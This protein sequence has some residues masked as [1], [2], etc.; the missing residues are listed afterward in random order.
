MH[1]GRNDRLPRFP[2]LLFDDDGWLSPCDSEDDVQLAVEPDFLYDIEAA[3]D[4]RG[5]P[6]VLTVRDDERVVPHVTG[7]PE[8]GE[9]IRR[10]RG[11]FRAWTNAPAPDLR[12][13]VE[14]WLPGVIPLVRATPTRRRRREPNDPAG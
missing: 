11:F 6:L 12:G 4:S 14:Q 8:P 7:P 13:G 5:C 10:V 2:C 3:F 9:L 1:T